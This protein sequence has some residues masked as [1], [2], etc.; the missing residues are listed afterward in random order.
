MCVFTLCIICFF[1]FDVY[2]IRTVCK[3]CMYMLL[4]DPRE[5]WTLSNVAF[6]LNKVIIIIIIIPAP[7]CNSQHTAKV[8]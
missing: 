5:D 7:G 4:E 8:C 6:S 1:C 3:H 2:L